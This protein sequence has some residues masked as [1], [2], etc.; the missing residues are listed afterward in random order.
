MHLLSF[1]TAGPLVSAFAVLVI[2]R[3]AL[4]MPTDEFSTSRLQLAIG[5]G[6][7]K[8]LRDWLDRFR[9][10]VW[11]SRGTHWYCDSTVSTSGDGKSWTSAFKTITEAVTA[12]SAGDYIHLWGS[13]AESVTCA[14]AGLRFVGEGTGPRQVLWAPVAGNDKVNLAITAAYVEVANVYF[15]PGPKSASYSACIT[16]ANANHARITGNRFQGST[17]SYY[18]IYSAACN[19]DNV[20]VTGNEFRYFN[21]ATYGAAILGVN[22][23]GFQ[24]SGWHITGNTFNSCVTAIKLSCKA[25]VIT[26]NVVQKG[27]VTADGATNAAVMALGID[28]QGDD[29][30][31]SGGNTV[32]ENVLD[33]AYTTDLYRA[34]ATGDCW[35]GNRCA[36]TTTT[37]PYGLSV[38]V[39]ADP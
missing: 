24:Y 19:S 25:A 36:I 11:T 28:L 17:G 23:G 20:H 18:A 9:K 32:S 35:Y 34:G 10:R 5:G 31:N 33:G 37:A 3:L 2:L 7:A 39:P 13:F 14:K 8:R 4:A 6:F 38:A 27:G 12:A 15:S 1:C 21:T 29:A 16:L 30:T 22:A 26:G